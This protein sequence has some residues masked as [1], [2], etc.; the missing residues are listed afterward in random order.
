MTEALEAIKR[1]LDKLESNVS[2]IND[3]VT[4]LYIRFGKFDIEFKYIKIL[5]FVLIGS[6]VFLGAKISVP[7]LG[8]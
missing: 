4:K 1:R 8:P 6:T 2:S 3:K 5:L 7:F